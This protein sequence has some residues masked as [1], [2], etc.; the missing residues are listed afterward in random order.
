M[1][2]QTLRGLAPGQ[3]LHWRG[4]AHAGAFQCDLP[5]SAGRIPRPVGDRRAPGLSRYSET[6]R[7]NPNRNPDNSLPAQ[8]DGDPVR[9]Q[10]LFNLHINHCAVCPCLPGH[11][12]NLDDPRNFGG[13]QPIKTPSLPDGVPAG[14][15]EF[16]RPGAVSFPDSV[17]AT[18]GAGGTSRFADS[19]YELDQFRGAPILLTWGP[20]S[21]V[22]IP[23]P[24]RRSVA[25]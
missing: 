1:T 2:T 18:I 25:L 5:G 23:G 17:W 4:I 7:P 14:A 19:L 6:S 24:H 9:G 22:L 11:R 15:A 21:A 8:L 10:T 16:A 13:T 12:Q 20:L 3:P